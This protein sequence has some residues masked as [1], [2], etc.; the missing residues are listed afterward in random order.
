MK[1]TFLAGLALA[2]ALPLS[3]QPGPGGPPPGG[4]GGPGGG[5]PPEVVLKDALG[6]SDAQLTQLH[7][8]L[9]A[10]RQAGE[11]L[12][13]Q[14]QAAQQALA[15]A[16]NAATPDPATVGAKLLAVRAIE[17]Q[18]QQVGEAVKTGFDAMLTAEQKT[19]VQG[20]QS[21]D[22]QMRALGALHGIGY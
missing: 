22:L 3:A 5:P 11:A 1:K 18:F 15:E 6:L 17:K 12:Q 9:D 19:K 8:L 10:R 21:L 20:L 14:M 16:L 4:P 7:T 2:L 13:Q